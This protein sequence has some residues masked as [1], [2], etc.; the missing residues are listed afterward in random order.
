MD[1]PAIPRNPIGFQLS[2]TKPE[3][4]LKTVQNIRTVKNKKSIKKDKR[5]KKSRE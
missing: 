3:G 1:P 2:N 5:V 4:D